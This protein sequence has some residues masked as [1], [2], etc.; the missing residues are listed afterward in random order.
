VVGSV[1]VRSPEYWRG[2]AEEARTLAEGMSTREGMQAML[3]VADLY[4]QLASRSE[5]LAEVYP[6]AKWMDE[7]A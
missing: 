2:R 3:Q 4:D 1:P 5:H 6:D 7:R